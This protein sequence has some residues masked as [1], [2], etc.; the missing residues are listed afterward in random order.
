MRTTLLFAPGLE[1]IL[2][3]VP[4]HCLESYHRSI[5]LSAKHQLDTEYKA[6]A[7]LLADLRLIACSILRRWGHCNTE[8]LLDVIACEAR[9]ETRLEKMVIV[10]SSSLARIM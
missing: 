4:K 6:R 8:H 10:P 9:H 2:D 5:V 3:R 1:A 7:T